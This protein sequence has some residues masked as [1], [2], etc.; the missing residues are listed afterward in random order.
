MIDSASG[1]RGLPWCSH[2]VLPWG[3]REIRKRGSKQSRSHYLG[4]SWGFGCRRDPR[5]CNARQSKR[6]RYKRQNRQVENQCFWIAAY[7]HENREI[8]TPWLKFL[9]ETYRTV[10]DILRNNPKLEGLYQVCVGPFCLMIYFPSA[11]YNFHCFRKLHNKPSHFVKSSREIPS[12]A[13]CAISSVV[14]FQT[15]ANMPISPTPSTSRYEDPPLK[16]ILHQHK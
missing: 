6:R 5:K 13:G 7:S 4:R 15:L 12:F 3:I 8:V 1:Q 9:W 11:H 14:I 10:L 16:I 2:Q